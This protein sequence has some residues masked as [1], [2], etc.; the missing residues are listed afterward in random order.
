MFGWVR[1][2][3][4]REHVKLVRQNQMAVEY[5]YEFA[6]EVYQTSL[7][8]SMMRDLEEVLD[9][10]AELIELLKRESELDTKI[11]E[12]QLRLQKHLRRIYDE[13]T[14]GQVAFAKQF[15]SARERIMTFDQ[16]FEPNEGWKIFITHFD[17]A[18]SAR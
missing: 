6:K 17:S 5:L 4:R 16:R 9:I 1:R 7:D 8:P 2:R 10:Q 13:K 12:D 3:V 14:A 18:N 11:S 15:G